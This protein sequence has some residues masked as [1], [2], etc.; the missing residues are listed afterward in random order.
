MIWKVEINPPIHPSSDSNFG[1]QVA[2]FRLGA[3]HM[4]PAQGTR[5]APYHH[6]NSCR[7]L[8]FAS[9]RDLSHTVSQA[10]QC[11]G[12]T[13]SRVTWPSSRTSTAATV[14]VVATQHQA[15]KALS[16]S[17]RRHGTR[18]RRSQPRPSRTAACFIS[19]KRHNIN[20]QSHI[21]TDKNHAA[22]AKSCDD[23]QCRTS[24]KRLK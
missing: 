21:P 8:R 15:A 24:R 20:Q 2:V 9:F 10:L 6:H 17:N 18:G 5:P 7:I 14:P 23:G 3:T 13:R 1:C 12:G 11:G 19:A 22:C 16:H 4:P